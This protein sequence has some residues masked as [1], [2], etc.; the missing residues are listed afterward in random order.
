[1]KDGT[2]HLA[3]KAKSDVDLKTDII[4]AAKIYHADRGD[5]ATLVDSVQQARVHLSEAEIEAA[6]EDVAAD[7]GYHAAPTVGLAEA[8]SL[9]TF[10]PGPILK[11]DRVW[12]DKPVGYQRVVYNNRRRVKR[13]KG[14]RFWFSRSEL[15]DRT[16][17][18]MCETGGARRTWLSGFENVKK[19]WLNQAA[20][21]NLGLIV[22][23]LFGI[24]TARSLQV[25]G[26]LPLR[27]Q[28]ACLYVSAC[29]RRLHWAITL[30]LALEPAKAL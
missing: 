11:H 13:A 18:H 7:K 23:K 4:L 10:I 30:R 1:M 24:G 3:Y 19:R 17:A 14:R 15:V 8:M 29:I 25:E 6:I 2:T 20:A 16:F 26:G 28:I 12:T 9:R 22:R 27:V 21:R 5:A